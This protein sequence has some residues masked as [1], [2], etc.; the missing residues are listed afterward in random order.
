MERENATNLTITR[1]AANIGFGK[2]AASEHILICSSLISFSQERPRYQT[3]K[4]VN[5][6]LNKLRGQGAGQT[7]C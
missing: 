7:E 4:L 3:E 2:M 5:S 6:T 1:S